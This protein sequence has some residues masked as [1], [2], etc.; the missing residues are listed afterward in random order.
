MEKKWLEWAKELQTLSQCGL[1]YSK[2]KFDIERFERIRSISVEI[3]SSYTDIE[4]DKMTHLFAG[5]EGYHTPKVDIRA[6]IFKDN[7]ILLVKE[8][9]DGKW[10]LPGGWA[11][12]GYTVF[13]NIKKESKEEAGV[14]VKPRKVIAILDRNKVIQDNFPYTVY[15]IFVECEYLFGEYE[16]NIETSESGFFTL[17]ALPE[18]SHSRNTIEQ[19]TMCFKAKDDINHVVICD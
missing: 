1:A 15:K 8:I 10:S 7:K 3:M 17:D 16:E 18:L 19:I 13:E 4:I 14:E 5:D 11:D 2:D 6:A 12:V 9:L